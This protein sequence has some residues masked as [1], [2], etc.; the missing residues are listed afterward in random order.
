MLWFLEEVSGGVLGEVPAEVLVGE[1]WVDHFL[2][3]PAGFA[4]VPIL[5]AR[6]NPHT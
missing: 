2:P 3:D 1:E 5:I 4:S 6:P